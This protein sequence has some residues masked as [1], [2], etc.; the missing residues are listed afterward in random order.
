M[1]KGWGLVALVGTLT[2]ISVCVILLEWQ[3]VGGMPTGL[4]HGGGSGAA[5][6]AGDGGRSRSE[7]PGGFL[8]KRPARLTASFPVPPE[9]RHAACVAQ[10]FETGSLPTVS[11]V[12]PY[13]NETWAQVSATVA[14]LLAYTPLE[15]VDQ[16]LFVDDGN[17]KE[18]Q[19]HAGLLAMHPKIQIHR[20]EERQGLIRSKVIGAALVQS[21]VVVFMEPH[22]IVSR[23]WLEPLLV[24]LQQDANH[25][26]IVMPILDIIPESNFNDYRVANHHIGGF[27]WSLTFNWMALIEERNHSYHYPDPYVTPALSGGI[28]AIWRDFW[29]RSGTYDV[30]MSEWGGE[31]IEMSLRTWR[32]GGSIKIVPCSRM[33]HVFRAK[34]PYVVHTEL[35]IRNQKRAA[36]VWLDTHMDDFYKEVPIARF[37]DAGDVSE[38]LKLKDTLQCKSMEWYIDNV[39][40]ELRSRQPRRR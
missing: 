3:A 30:A 13:L 15:V 5:P 12:I 36:L 33:G 2:V 26:T 22:C 32:C 17:A 35:V 20:N 25:S 34:N 10:T 38:R 23:H 6:F 31:H 29:E 39:Y 7:A 21:P 24:E 16:I 14:S 4:Q 37:I 18:W 9:V 28:F 8:E 40:P 1:F 11:L 19:H 27:D